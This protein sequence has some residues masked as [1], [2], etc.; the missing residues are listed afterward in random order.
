MQK[1][2]R[3]W[4]EQGRVDLF[5]ACKMSYG[6]PLP[7]VFSRGNLDECQQIVPD[8]FKYPLDKFALTLARQHPEL[9]IGI[10]ARDCTQRS[11]NILRVW[12]QLEPDQIRPL[13]LSCCPSR[14][15]DSCDC[16]YLNPGECGQWKKEVGLDPGLS[17]EDVRD[18]PPDERFSRWMYEF[19]KC[20]K[21]YG[22]RNICP[23]CFCR[24]C[25]LEH[26]DLV[27]T[28]QFLSEV[29]IFHLTRAVHM[30]GRCIDCGLCEQACPVDIPL[31]LLYSMVNQIVLD[32][33]DYQTGTSQEQ[34]PLNMLGTELA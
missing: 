2:I 16:S 4:I 18:M 19:S 14:L 33:F 7:H 31:R 34:A 3:S 26:P 30:A 27:Q 5:I 25:S 10:L 11:L 23:V 15:A 22:C 32:K 13:P 9:K 6:H 8:T 12:N 17:P 21:C 1:T 28:G 29:P 20:I 24:E